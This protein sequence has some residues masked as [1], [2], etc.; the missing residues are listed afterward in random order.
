MPIAMGMDSAALLRGVE[1]LTWSMTPRI[2]ITAMAEVAMMT[3]MPMWSSLCA[4]GSSFVGEDCTAVCRTDEALL[5]RIVLM[6]LDF[7]LSKCATLP[8]RADELFFAGM[9]AS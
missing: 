1:N 6:D 5:C 7:F 2:I 4:E 3:C 9:A 8:L